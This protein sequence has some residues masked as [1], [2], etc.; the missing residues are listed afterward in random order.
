MEKRIAIAGYMPKRG[1]AGALH[2][3]MRDTSFYATTPEP[4]NWQRL[5][6][7]GS[8]GWNDH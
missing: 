6:Y 7:Y 4:R 5:Y 2:Q 1:N 8:D 3:L